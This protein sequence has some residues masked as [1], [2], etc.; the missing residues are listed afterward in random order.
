M[1]LHIVARLPRPK[2]ETRAIPREPDTPHGLEV[3]G[4]TRETNDFVLC[5]FCG[6]GPANRQSNPLVAE[7]CLRFDT[8]P[9][10]LVS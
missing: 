2:V 8:I 3:C 6:F 4:G 10:P 9:A 5:L 1:H 7:I